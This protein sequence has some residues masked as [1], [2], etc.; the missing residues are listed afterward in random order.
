M[1]FFEPQL[2]SHTL[3]FGT[4]TRITIHK[5]YEIEAGFSHPWKCAEIHLVLRK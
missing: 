2:Q 4:Q 3:M 1:R 5:I